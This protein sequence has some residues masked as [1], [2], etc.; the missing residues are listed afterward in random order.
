MIKNLISSFSAAIIALAMAS[1]AQADTKDPLGANV[2]VSLM[3]GWTMAN[4]N[5]MAALRVDLAPGWHTYWRAPGAAG[6]PPVFRWMGNSTAIQAKYHWPVPTIYSQNGMRF[7]GY[8]DSLILPIEF[9]PS[10]SGDIVVS[11][12]V[13]LGVC[14]DVCMPFTAQLDA[15]F[16]AQAAA[17]NK[18]VIQAQ[19][20]AKPKRITSAICDAKPIADG[21]KL[22]ATVN[23]PSL[24]ATEMAVIEHPDPSIWVSEATSMRKGRTVTMSSD[25]VPT[26]AAPFLLNRSQVRLTVIGEDGKAYETLGCKAS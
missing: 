23:I 8:E 21:I 11:G 3:Q 9:T 2:Q 1:S 19:L 20:N 26:N 4:G 13:T 22:S 18:Q 12:A 14:D 17:Q 16:S 5:Y 7:L 24:G 25:M 6:I 15:H 10:A